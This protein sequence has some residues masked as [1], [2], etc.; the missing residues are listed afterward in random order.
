VSGDTFMK[1]EAK[2]NS[3]GIDSSETD[4]EQIIYRNLED[5]FRSEACVHER[6]FAHLN[7]RARLIADVLKKE[8]GYDDIMDAVTSYRE[9]SEI[10][11]NMKG[12]AQDFL[13][14]FDKASLNEAECISS[15]SKK[16][17]DMYLCKRISR[18]ERR[19]YEKKDLIRWLS[20]SEDIPSHVIHDKKVS[21]V[22]G[23]Q[24][25][26]AFERFAKY[27]PG[28]LAEYEEDF[29][30]G[31]EAVANGETTYAIVP[32]E[33]S[34]DGRLNSFYRLIEKHALSIVLTV[35]IPS[36]DYESNTKFA[37]VYKSIDVIPAEGTEI[38]ECKISFSNQKDVANILMAAEYFGAEVYKLYSLPPSSGIM[39]NSFDIIFDISGADTAALICYL[40]LEYPY[41]STI[42]LYT[43]T[44]EY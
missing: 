13:D 24:A 11:G 7:E 17:D 14:Y 43:M 29:K 40:F 16:L 5:V 19:T 42:G 2:L 35:D 36:D 3:F 33:N 27:V 9:A 22:R 6:K 20:E 31:C 25:G 26:R 39:E 37:L 4:L 8:S 32:I 21:F 30:S 1:N 12:T 10:Y 28:V 18:Y 15:V 34:L 41:F 38:F 23:S 44:E